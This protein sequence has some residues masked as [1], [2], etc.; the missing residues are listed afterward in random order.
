MLLPLGLLYGGLYYL[1]FDQFIRRFNLSTPGREPQEQ[2]LSEQPAQALNAT[3]RTAAYI[4]ALGGAANFKVVD[5]CTTR[6]RLQLVDRELANEAQLKALGA[7]AVVKPGPS[8]SL[9]VVVGPQA[10]SLAD[11]IRQ[12]LPD[13][14]TAPQHA[15]EDPAEHAL[16]PQVR[17][18]ELEPELLEKW[19]NALGGSA[20]VQLIEHVAMTRMRL[21]LGD[22]KQIN[23]AQ[24]SAL[25]ALGIS[26]LDHGICHVL[27]GAQA[28]PLSEAL[29]AHIA[30]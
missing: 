16:L 13:I 21:R 23:T 12:A 14:D 19:L 20:N 17:Q 2:T 11:K 7:M 4:K 30:D 25:G 10:D 28:K 29:L 1:V 6:L 15:P 22:V 5:A 27:L 18:P 8:S 3:E 24:L 9:Q 26:Y